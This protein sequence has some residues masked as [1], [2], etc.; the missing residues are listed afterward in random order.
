MSA[1]ISA[2]HE[3]PM[4]GVVDVVE[5]LSGHDHVDRRVD[6]VQRHVECLARFSS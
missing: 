1:P 5:D 2:W 3:C 4:S 6:H